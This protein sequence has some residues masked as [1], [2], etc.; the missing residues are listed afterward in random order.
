MEYPARVV[1]VPIPSKG[2]HQH[3]S[4]QKHFQLEG[5]TYR[6]LVLLQLGLHL[7]YFLQLSL[8]G[9]FVGISGLVDEL[10]GWSDI[11]DFI[12]KGH[13]LGIVKHIRTNDCYFCSPVL[14][15][16]S[17]ELVVLL[18][19]LADQGGADLFLA[20][21]EEGQHAQLDAL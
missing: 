21:L 14:D 17:H 5:R 7:L 20:S 15:V 2:Y 16:D 19:F 10:F 3:W 4:L 9:L 18:V 12:E 8:F 13:T 6:H 11:H 1:V